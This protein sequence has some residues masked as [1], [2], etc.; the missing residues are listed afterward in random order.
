MDRLT[1]IAGTLPARRRRRPSTTGVYT[2][3]REAIIAGDL[4][5]GERLG[6]EQ[7]ARQFDVSRTPVREAIFRLEAERLVE[8]SS[9]R[10]L[11]V[12]RILEEEI[13][14]VYVVRAA[15][16]GLAASLAATV[17]LAADQARL[18]WLND[19]LRE[20]VRRGDFGTAAELDIQFHEGLAEAAHNS[21]LLDLMRQLHDWVR[22]FGASTLSADG[23]AA[24][25]LDEHASILQAIESGDGEAAERRARSHIQRAQQALALSL[26]QTIR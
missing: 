8:R 20:A 18:R 9:A 26:R 25:A 2:S 7:L 13:L 24:A 15:L 6:E 17:G 21:M 11:V 3:L 5:A 19:R 4:R 16:D 14:E 22:R 10:G 23:R 12:R 1:S